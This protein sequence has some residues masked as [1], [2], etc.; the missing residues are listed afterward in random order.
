MQQSFHTPLVLTA[1]LTAERAMELFTT[2]GLRSVV[3]HRVFSSLHDGTKTE[4][5]YAACAGKGAAVVVCQGKMSGV[6]YGG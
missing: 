4:D 1:I 5:M 3:L 6:I 2:L